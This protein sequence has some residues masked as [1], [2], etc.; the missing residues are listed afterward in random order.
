MDNGGFHTIGVSL[1]A[2]ETDISTCKSFAGLMWNAYSFYTN[3]LRATVHT[4]TRVSISTIHRFRLTQSVWIALVNGC[5]LHAIGVSRCANEAHFPASQSLT[6]V[7]TGACS[8]L[9]YAAISRA[10]WIDAWGS[11]NQWLV[12][13]DPSIGFTGGCRDFTG[14]SRIAYRLGI[15][16]TWVVIVAD[17]L[18]LLAGA[19][20]CAASGIATWGSID[21]GLV[22][23]D[24]SIGFARG[25][26]DL[27][28]I[29]GFAIGL[30]RFWTWL[31]IAA[32]HRSRFA[33]TIVIAGFKNI[34]FNAVGISRR[35]E[36]ASVAARQSFTG[37]K[38]WYTW[39]INTA[40]ARL[41]I[42]AFTG[43]DA[44]VRTTVTIGIMRHKSGGTIDDWTI[45]T[46]VITS[47]SIGINGVESRLAIDDWTILTG[48]ITSISIGINGVESRLAVDDWTVLAEVITS[49]AILISGEGSRWAIH[50]LARDT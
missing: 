13:T 7:V 10:D 33:E 50:R 11:I 4:V 49:I 3:F 40:F 48:V 1:W 45:L 26:W 28:R 31:F 44:C 39:A 16:R 20:P 43:I 21:K 14:V 24:P 38:T 36:D 19:R 37:V 23:T 18:T 35:A 29:T 27:A 8:L 15:L 34:R 47:I 2:N 22:H 42:N 5:G 17:A 6:R 46:G 41:T 32:V 12:Y 25:R 9:A 30:V